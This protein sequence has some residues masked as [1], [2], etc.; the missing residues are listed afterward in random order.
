MSDQSLFNDNTSSTQTNPTS[1][2]TPPDPTADLL[3]AITNTEGKQKY[4]NTIEAL[5]ALKHSQEFIP[6]LKTE[7]DTTKAELLQAK[8]ALNRMKEL[9]ATLAKLTQQK[10]TDDPAPTQSQS[11]SEDDVA[12]LVDRVLSKKSAEQTAIENTNLVR[13]SVVNAFGEKAQEVFYKKAAE[14]GLSNA[15]MNALAAKSPK[16]V[17]TALGIQDKAPTEKTP[18][19]TSSTVNTSGFPNNPPSNLGRNTKSIMLGATTQDVMQES[20]LARKMVDELHAQGKTVHDLTDPK[21]YFAT[22][23]RQG[24]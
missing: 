13:D 9:E 2:N 1:D 7:L 20:A 18:N 6:Q 24:N 16:V 11:L 5:N 22:F 3:K 12:S 4:A 14:L 19:P 21:V 10:P 8:E 17:L 23:N 15:E